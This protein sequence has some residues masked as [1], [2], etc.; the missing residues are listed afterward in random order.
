MRGR[1]WPG[2][3]RH[4]ASFPERKTWRATSDDESLT[5]QVSAPEVQH[6]GGGDDGATAQVVAPPAAGDEPQAVA[7]PI[8][9]DEPSTA[10][11]G[12]PP[13]AS[14]ESLTV[15]AATPL[16]AG[17]EPPTAQA[18]AHAS[19]PEAQRAA[20]DEDGTTAQATAPP[21]A[22]DE[23]PIALA[24]AHASAPE[25]QRAADGVVDEDG[26]SLVNILK[27]MLSVCM[28]WPVTHDNRDLTPAHR[29][30][31]SCGAQVAWDVARGC[32]QV[33]IWLVYFSSLLVSV[34]PF[35]MLQPKE[36]PGVY[37]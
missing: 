3:K 4:H 18:A 31:G 34:P 10:Q 30:H 12:A 32:G 17:D 29:T 24:A 36:P 14:D 8:V 23:P 28:Y 22:G 19:A 20:D 5:T 33:R 9:G 27:E 26:L 21:V 15:Q 25:A 6:A 2:R 7:P 35:E 16:I 37:C 1:C 11:A 13:V